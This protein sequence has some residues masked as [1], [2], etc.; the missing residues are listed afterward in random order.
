MLSENRVITSDLVKALQS[1][2]RVLIALMLREARTRYGRQRAGYLWA[3][4]EPMLHIA[5]FYFVFRFASGWSRS[6]KA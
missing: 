3:L 4:V 2:G 5:L 6:A 1:Q